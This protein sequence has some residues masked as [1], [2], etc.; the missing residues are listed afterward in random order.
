MPS[1]S[2]SGCRK[3]ISTSP[4]RRRPASSARRLL[5][6][7]D[8][9]GL[10]QD[11][12]D[13]ARARLGVRRVGE[14]RRRRRRP[15]DHDLEA[16]AGE[17]R[18]RPRERARRAARRAPSPSGRRSSCRG[19]SMQAGRTVGGGRS[20]ARRSRKRRA[21]TAT[22][23]ALSR[24][25]EARDPHSSGHAARVGV[26]AEVIAERLG[27]DEVDVDVL[28]IGRGAPRRRQAAR[29]GAD[30]AQARP[31]RR[32]R[33][34]GDAPPS[35]GGRAHGRARQRAAARGSRRSLP[36]RAL[37]RHRLSDRHRGR[38]DPGRG[39]RARGRR[40]VRRDDHRPLVPAGTARGSSRSPSSSAAR[41]RSSTPRS[42]ASS[43]RRGAT[44]RST[45]AT[46]RP[47]ARRG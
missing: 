42:S 1:W 21:M 6:L 24:A 17:P 16:G 44:A 2:V 46:V 20:T 5:H 38:G 37:G 40:R 30:P 39:A 14:G 36:P 26:M 13:E 45:D 35:G 31:A 12:V 19:N 43:S 33:A 34:R 11:A 3:P 4:W 18:R 9:L 28:R 47:R 22:L 41:G 32:G 10:A 25:I 7:D 23:L 27:W 8:S 29:A 15:L